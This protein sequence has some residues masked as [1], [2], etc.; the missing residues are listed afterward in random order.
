MICLYRSAVNVWLPSEPRTFWLIPVFLK[1]L[2]VDLTEAKGIG[3]NI[4]TD[5]LWGIF[6]DTDPRDNQCR[7]HSTCINMSG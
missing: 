7:H 1:A 2:L 5:G 3:R 4:I 6:R